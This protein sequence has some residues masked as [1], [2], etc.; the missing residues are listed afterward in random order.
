[1]L[2]SLL[3]EYLHFL[4]IERNLS[5]NTHTAYQFDLM[6]FID[7]F[8]AQGIT[9][10]QKIREKNLRDWIHEFSKHNYSPLTLSRHFSALKGFFKYLVMEGYITI[11]PS[12]ILESP[13]MAARLPKILSIED[14]EKLFSVIPLDKPRGLRDR[15]FFELLYATGMRVS[16]ICNLT[17]DKIFFDDALVQVIGKG[18]KERIVPMG[19]ESQYWLGK[20]LNEGREN[21]KKR[22]LTNGIVFLNN[23]GLGLQRKGV[24][25]LL[26]KYAHLAGIKK[27]LS[28]HTFRHSFATHLLEGGA[29][30]RVVQELLGHSDLTTTQIYTHLDNRYLF[31][32]FQSFHP[33]ARK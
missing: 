22:H 28:P 27:P 25:F 5:E 9:S 32:V 30:L 33:R 7:F 2:K 13:R 21:L 26:K 24:W 11:D 6:Q 12:K 18:N 15:A 8:D 20:Y 4:R 17:I 3:T 14:I 19:E 10:P 1:M 29:D 31:E 16:E 23:R